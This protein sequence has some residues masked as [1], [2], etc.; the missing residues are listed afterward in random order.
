MTPDRP[1]PGATM[2]DPLTPRKVWVLLRT[3]SGHTTAH[4]VYTAREAL[5]ARVRRIGARNPQYPLRSVGKNH[6]T[7]GPTEDEGFFGDKPV[8]LD[9]VE[10]TMDSG[11]DDA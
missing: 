7:I 1:Q 11:G 4:A 10:V 2:P 3:R 9:A 8:H 5:D 6:W